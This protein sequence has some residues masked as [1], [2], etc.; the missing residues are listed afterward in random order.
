MWK[1]LGVTSEI[2]TQ[3]YRKVQLLWTIKKRGSVYFP[4]YLLQKIGTTLLQS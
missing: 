2:A 3:A 4:R 1:N